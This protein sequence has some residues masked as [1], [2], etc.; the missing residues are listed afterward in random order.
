[1]NR[2]ADASSPYLLQHADNPVDWHPWG[3]PAF[4]EA[5]E[6]DRPILLS[7]GYSACHWCHVMAHESFEDPATA[8]LM[9]RWFV[10]VKVDREERPDVDRI[11]M[12]A[13]QAM[14][15]R[16]GW[17]MTVFLTPDGRPFYAG[18]YFPNEDR[19]GMP[20]F[21]KILGAI[22]AA[23]TERRED[24]GT[25]ADRMVEA[26][27]RTIPPADHLPDAAVL[28]AAYES[29][30]AAYDDVRGGFGGAPK[31]PQAPTLEF[32]LRISGR[33][34]APEASRMLEGTLLAMARGGIH[35]Q[36]GGG[37]ARYAVDA[38]W[39]VPHF[40]KMLY[41]NA[42]LARLYARAAQV[43]GNPTLAGVARRTVDYMLQDLALPNGGF[44]SAEDADSEGEEGVFYTF[45][46]AEFTSVVGPDRS[47]AAGLAFGIT[48]QGNFEGTNVLTNA[49][50]AAEIAEATGTTVEAAAA[51]KEAAGA[52]LL[53]HRNRRI[54]PGLDDKAVCAWNGLAIRGL[55]EV[56]VALGESRYVDAAAETARWVLQEMRRSDGRLLRARRNGTGDIPA[57]SEDYAAMAVALFTLYQATGDQGWFMKAIDLTRNLIDL[58]WDDVDGGVFAAGNDAED[59]VARPK[60]LYDNPTPSDNSLAAEALQFAAAFTGDAHYLSRLDD[61]FRLGGRLM[62]TYPSAVGH[63]LSLAAVALAPPKEVAIIGPPDSP[64]TRSLVDVVRSGFRPEVFLAVGEDDVEASGVPLLSGRDAGES[65]LAYVCRGFVCDAPTDDPETLAAQLGA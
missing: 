15:G 34:W 16:G 24:I 60:N 58:F 20:S 39:L 12:D 27:R 44:A 9:N 11:Y 50:T 29:L 45:T 30:A 38:N 46:H 49:M 53:D 14:T 4:S 64:A 61:I 55:A 7:V 23:W 65:A 40:E 25:Q 17:P 63:L 51:A 37:F 35:D 22:H 2:L 62:G 32:L 3:E 21:Q 6:R 47:K 54:R 57:F 43:T 13:V 10:N 42:L 48:P 41:D 59:L 36:L 26:I 52:D 8:E 31:F 19:H 18:T 28:R 5:R 33:D 1:M 56:G